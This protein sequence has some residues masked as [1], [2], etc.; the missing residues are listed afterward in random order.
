MGGGGSRELLTSPLKGRGVIPGA[1]DV[2]AV[3]CGVDEFHS[4]FVDVFRSIYVKSV[5]DAVDI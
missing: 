2:G 1:P 4:A 5:L 3:G